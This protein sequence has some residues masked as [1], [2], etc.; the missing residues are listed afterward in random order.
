MLLRGSKTLLFNTGN[1]FAS[2]K[3][4]WSAANSPRVKARIML[5][6][7]FPGPYMRAPSNQ[8]VLTL[9]CSR[10]VFGDD[11]VL[12]SYRERWKGIVR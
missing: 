6:H 9:S 7:A 1:I 3:S 5:V 10:G 8:G 12:V 4:C 11:P 2:C